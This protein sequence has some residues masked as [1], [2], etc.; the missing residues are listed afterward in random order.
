[1]AGQEWF[2]WLVGHWSEVSTGLLIVAWLLWSWK[3]KRLREQLEL[4]LSALVELAKKY[5]GAVP[6][7]KVLEVANWAY[8]NLFM[9]GPAWM[10][11][12]V[13][14][15]LGSREKFGE[16]VWAKWSEFVQ[17]RSLAAEVVL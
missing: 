16:M 7:E 17:L 5:G 6:K 12:A 13:G 14:M 10:D 11:W 3:E 9:A 8:D 2:E 1:M 4:A 15:I